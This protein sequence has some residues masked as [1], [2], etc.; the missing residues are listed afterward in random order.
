M[1]ARICT[2]IRQH[3][4]ALVALFL[5]LGGTA[6]AVD[7]PLPGTNQ[8]GSEDIINN[9]VKSADI[10][11]G[12]IFNL[13]LAD[14]II[15]SGKIQDGTLTG[16]DINESTLGQVPSASLGGIG[17]FSGGNSCDPE[18]DT[19]QTCAAVTLNLPGQA[20]VA[21][22]ATVRGTTEV[23]ADF[24]VGGCRLGTSAT[25][26]LAGTLTGFFAQDV[27]ASSRI[28]GSLVAVTP[29]LGPGSVSFGVE[30]NQSESQGAISYDLIGI[31]AVAVS[32]N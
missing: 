21:L 20:R 22:N 26:A 5:A 18:S 1:A 24:A 7:G 8:V 23:D 17:R 12:R 25:G 3:H 14:N 4:L 27:A 15:Q 31:S 32:P 16:G 29:P 10:A 9:D 2:Y 30:C 13:D 28:N 11:D 6:Y 19:F